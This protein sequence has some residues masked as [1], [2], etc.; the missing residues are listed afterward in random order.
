MPDHGE[1]TSKTLTD[2]KLAQYKFPLLP[3]S[4]VFA[5]LQPVL[6]NET[7]GGKQMD[8]TTI[9]EKIQHD[10]LYKWDQKV[11][12]QEIR[13]SETGKLKVLSQDSKDYSF[14]EI[15]TTQMCQKLAIPVDYY[16]RLPGEMK[17]TVTNF[18]LRRL[19][20]AS[21]LLRGK[22]DC[23]RAFLSANYVVYNN[24]QIMETLTALLADAALSLKSF[25]LEESHLYIKLVSEQIVDEASGLKAGVMIGNSEVGQGSVSVEPFVFRKACTNDLV[26]AQEKS[27][28][29]P[30]IHLRVSELNVRMGEGISHAFV[31]ANTAIDAFLRAREEPVP[32]PVA[33][34]RSIAAARKLS[35]KLTDQ[36]LSC[37]GA[38]PEPNRFGLINAFT[39]A[40]RTLAPLHRIE[41]ERFAGTL[42]N[43]RM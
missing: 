14:S 21:Y 42:L 3:D 22:G 41:M 43:I 23:I 36:V 13:V 15:A 26:V 4:S 11:G 24:S 16:R 28:R 7:K 29:H 31:V 38:D 30:H 5:T 27:F 2:E 33:T 1:L 40:A 25:V 9:H 20:D 10:D 32:D 19:K 34:I 18:D 17:A 39:G 8:W 37:Y 35:Q 12:G 6:S